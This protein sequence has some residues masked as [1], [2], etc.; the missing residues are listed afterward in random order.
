MYIHVLVQTGTSIPRNKDKNKN[1]Q[2]KLTTTK[3]QKT[4]TKNPNACQIMCIFLL[5]KFVMGWT[6]L[7]LN[8]FYFQVLDSWK[9][10]KTILY[11][12]FSFVIRIPVIFLGRIPNRYWKLRRKKSKYSTWTYRNAFTYWKTSCLHCKRT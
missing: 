12:C 2:K 11:A 9:S 8:W 4:T 1:D 5:W 7:L 3:T 6:F 10:Y